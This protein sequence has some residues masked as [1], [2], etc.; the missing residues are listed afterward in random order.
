MGIRLQVNRLRKL[1]TLMALALLLPGVV[2]VA[3]GGIEPVHAA[4]LNDRLIRLENHAAGATTTYEVG[5]TV[6]TSQQFGSI[7][8]EFCSNNPFPST[9]CTAPNGFDI[10]GATLASQSGEVGFVKHAATTTNMMVLSRVP[11]GPTFAPARYVFDGVVSPSDG[12][13]S[14]FVRV[15]TRELSGG[16]GAV[17]D[18]GGYAFSIHQGLGVTAYVPPYLTFCVA[19]SIP[20]NSCAS[21]TGSSIDFGEFSPTQTSS[22]T[23]Q[24]LA[25]TN[26]NGGYNITVLGTTMTAGNNVITALTSPSA[27]QTGL[28]QFGLNLR[29]NAAPNDGSNPSGPGSGAAFGDYGIPNQFVFRSGDV[30]A[31]VTTPN[32]ITRYTTTYIVNV[33]ADQAPGIYATTISFI[34]AATF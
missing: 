21:G 5:F 12:P 27:S 32:D 33:S 20:T 30:I 17:V 9:P 14:Y 8:F 13:Q 26:G 4:Q 3:L 28:S 25:A 22:G 23:S 2:P 7:E 16:G 18:A 29:D 31:G 15:Q 34:A 19:I 11:I 1:T 24:M 6:V 10:S